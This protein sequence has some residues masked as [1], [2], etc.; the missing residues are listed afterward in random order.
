MSVGL[1]VVKTTLDPRAG[2]LAW[3]LRELVW[4]RPVAPLT[5]G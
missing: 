3:Q 1:E 2:H 5:S 4:Q